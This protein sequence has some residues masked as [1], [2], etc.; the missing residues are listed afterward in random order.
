[1]R[2]NHGSVALSIVL[3]AL[4]CF[5]QESYAQVSLRGATGKAQQ[6]FGQTPLLFESNQGQVD[7]QVKFLSQGNGYSTFLTSGSMILSLRPTEV[8]SGVQASLPAPLGAKGPGR[9][10]IRQLEMAALAQKSPAITFGID[11]VGSKANPQVVGE[12]PRSTKVNYFIGR[13]PKKW[14]TNVPTYGRVRYRDVYPGIDLIY[15]SNDR[16]MEYDFYLAA[17]ADATKIKF[18][19]KGADDLSVDS[20]GNLVLSKGASQVRFRTPVLYQQIDGVRTRVPGAY[21]WHGGTNV[22]FEVGPYDTTKPLVIDPVLVY[23]TYIGG[24]NDDFSNGVAV[25]SSGDAYV[26]GITDSLDFPLV[27]G[28]Y[29]P[30]KS[31]VYRMFLSKFNSTGS[32]LLFTDYFGGTSGADEA[33]GVALDSAGN[34]YVTGSTLSADFPVVNA[35]QPTLAGSQDAFLT[36]FH[37]DGSSIVYS[38]YL[39]GATL[40]SIGGSTAQI[41]NSVSVDPSGEAV[42]AGVTTATDF[43]TT[44]ANQASVATDQFGDWGIYGFLTKFAAN[45]T[46]LVYSTYAGGSNL[47][48]GSCTGCFP[49]SEPLSV[50][51]DA[52]GNA[53]ITGYTTTTDFPVTGGA[54]ATSFPG[55]GVSDVGFVSKFSSGG[56]LAYSTY[57]GGLTSSFLNAIAVDSSGSAYVTGYDTAGDGFP[58]V[59]TSICDPGVASCNG[60]V[61]AKLDPTGASL[62]YSTFLGSSNS[63]AGQAIQVDASGNAFIVGSDVQFD[64][65]NQIEG[66]AGNGDVVVAEIDPSASSVLMATFLGGQGWDAASGLALDSSGAVY[67]IGV[68]QSLDFPVTQSGVQTAWGGQTD[69]FI[70]KIDPTTNAPAVAMGPASLQFASQNVGSTSA[71]LTTILRN[72]GTSALTITSK[73]TSGDFAETDDCSATVA[74]ASF[75]TFSI[76]FTP[77]AS[78]NRTGAL[79]I[80]DDATGSP[81]VVNLAGTGAVGPEPF[82]ANPSILTFATS[83]V[84]SS[85]STQSVTVTNISNSTL[86]LNGAQATGDFSAAMSNCRSVAAQGTCTVQISF[87]PT[88]AGT[89]T[90]T[91]YLTSMA[92]GN[93]QVSLTGAGI[94]FTTTATTES[95]AVQAGGSANYQLSL[96]SIGGNF[97]N[98]VSFTCTGVPAYATCT[99]TPQSIIPNNNSTTVIVSVHTTGEAAG[100][101]PFG[102]RNRFLALWIF[103]QTALFGVL[104]LGGNYGKR[105]VSRTGLAILTLTLLLLAGCGGKGAATSSFASRVQITPSGT[106]TLNVL[107]RSGNATHSLPL[108]LTVQ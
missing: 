53:Y 52:S 69:A 101:V 26:V 45:G 29:D 75:C 76:T 108:T 106:Y 25:D 38:T 19:V 41:G 8:L 62:S 54:F 96:S 97:S 30:G 66:Y 39:G 11:L 64:L 105:L 79:T 22:G 84:G 1:M 82:I 17:G 3:I 63:M 74:A 91:L 67:V 65:S 98:P 10:S 21:A 40:N 28:A 9:S 48:I 71:P 83:D 58:I 47:N 103:G 46:S 42:V 86:S 95:V 78:G 72:M 27:A 85:S 50:A 16:S 2:K 35:Y 31:H 6:S 73:T 33:Y 90:G 59:S 7:S 92:G 12:D 49:D 55:S 60:A 100:I 57:L 34:A 68:T 93:S 81:H 4:T 94:D 32:A 51:T 36:K 14:R 99:I 5:A 43:P 56:S 37:A 18:N 104:L 87:S 24:S 15:Y 23:S 70:A 61:I 20:D 80:V 44:N 89:R 13:D 107:S 77:T 88:A 102:N